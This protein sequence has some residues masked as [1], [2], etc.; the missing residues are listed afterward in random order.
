MI[1][2]IALD[3]DGTLTTSKKEITLH[4]KQ[5]LHQCIDRGVNIVLASGRPTAGVWHVARELELDKRGGYI[6]SYNG[7]CIFDCRTGKV[8]AQE[9]VPHELV[10]PVCQEAKKAGAACMSYS[11]EAILTEYPNDPYVELESRTCKIPVIAV[12]DLGK[13]IDFDVNKILVTMDPDR[14]PHVEEHMQQKFAGKLSMYKSSPFFL[15]VVPLGVEKAQSLAALLTIL[16]LTQE[17]L[18]ACGDSWND[19][20]MIELAGV[21]IA[22]GNAVPEVKCKATWITQDNNH[23]GV[24]VAIEKWV[25]ADTNA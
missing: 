8:L 24:A 23:D 4:T 3:L 25:L 16:G 9:V 12:E 5:V 18:M 19:I 1:K 6:L 14:M 2:L 7:G 20:S 15:E 21:G 22:M 17:N 11:S 13:A 10:A